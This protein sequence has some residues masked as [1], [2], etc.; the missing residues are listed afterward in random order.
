MAGCERY[1]GRERQPW[2]G[3]GRGGA[4]EH[5]ARGGQQARGRHRVGEVGVDEGHILNMHPASD[6]AAENGIVHEFM[7]IAY[8]DLHWSSLL[9][10]NWALPAQVRVLPSAI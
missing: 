7:L 1:P 3:R 5:P 9:G 4:P 2:G 6:I 8:L 10:I